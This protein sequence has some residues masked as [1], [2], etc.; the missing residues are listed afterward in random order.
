MV[1]IKRHLEELIFNELYGRQ[2]RFIAGPRQCGKTTLAKQKLK[3]ENCEELYY[4]WDN[5][6]VKMT[7]REKGNFLPVNT[8]KK[9]KWVCFDEIHKIPRWKN[10]LKGFFDVYE[11]E[12]Y[13]IITGSARIDIMRKSG[14]S[15]T[16]RYFL[17]ILNPFILSEIEGNKLKNLE[18]ED[19]A[20]SFIFKNLDKQKETQNKME[21]LIK[22]SGFPE[23]F[24]KSNESFL[25]LWNKEYFET[26]AKMDLRDISNI[27]FLEKLIDIIYLL[28]NRVGSPLSIDSISQDVELNFRTVKR[29]IDYLSLSYL[30]FFLSP[31]TGNI[32]RLNKKMKKLYFYNYSIINDEASKFENYVALELKT[33]IELWN[34]ISKDNYELFYLRNRE[35]Q[36]IDFVIVKNSKPFILIETKLNPSKIDSHCKYFS[37]KF[38]GIPFLQLV[39]QKNIV[40]KEDK[41]IFIISASRFFS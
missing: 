3:K 21:D 39:K 2:M 4:N 18:S 1:Y 19:D 25:K 17:F 23:P 6:D 28:P 26:I 10:I 14:D 32:K 31:Y 27:Q 9:K 30:V 20:N 8:G 16:G 41:N 40:R 7:Y 5:V 22:F 38:G 36:E 24:I 34:I 33:R 29:Y 35:G 11:D 13:F 37:A 15:L 12:Y